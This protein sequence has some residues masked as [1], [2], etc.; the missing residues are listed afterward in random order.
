M[1]TT[2]LTIYIGAYTQKLSFV[3]GKAKGISAFNFDLEFGNLKEIGTFSAGIN[4][5][6]LALSPDHNFL[7]TVNEV[8]QGT[9]PNGWVTAFSI[10]SSNGQLSLL[11]RQSTLGFSPCHLCIAGNGQFVI[12]ANYESGNICLMRRHANG[13]LEPPC[14]SVQFYGNG[15][16]PRQASAHAHMVIP[17]PDGRF[18]LAVDLGSDQIWAFELDTNLGKLLPAN[19]PKI[20]LPRGSGPR[21]LAFHPNQKFLYVLGELDSTV[22][23]LHYHAKDGIAFPV[24][25]VATLPQNFQEENT[26]AEIQVAPSGKFVYASNRGHNC[27]AILAVDPHDGRLTLIGHQPALGNAPRHFTFDPSGKYIIT[28][29]QDSDTL[30]VF[31]VDPSSGFLEPTGPLVHSP[32][33][34]CVQFA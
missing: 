8:T 30:A 24:E 21:H 28:A 14:D 23:L 17:T 3:D 10:D 19:P 9:G 32:T 15:P 34:V 25:T 2:N 13:Y 12:A 26:G 27:L 29:N 20:Q 7:Y 16:H 33:P 5:T 31:Q 18:I 1:S 22:T 4:P 11:N 6:F